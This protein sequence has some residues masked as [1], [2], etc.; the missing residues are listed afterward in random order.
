M[1]HLIQIINH[2]RKNLEYSAQEIA[3][4][5]REIAMGHTSVE[6]ALEDIG[7]EVRGPEQLER[8]KAA[9]PKY[10][11]ALKVMGINP[12]WSP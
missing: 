1:L 12:G 5:F 11:S 6:R 9:L 8:L 2:M 3:D 7:L 4:V 10:K